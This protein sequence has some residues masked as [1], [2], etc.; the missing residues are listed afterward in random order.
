MQF[1]TPTDNPDVLSQFPRRRHAQALP[2]GELILSI[3]DHR[4]QVTCACR[5]P[6]RPVLLPVGRWFQIE[7]LLPQRGPTATGRFH[8]VGST[9]SSTTDIVGPPHGAHPDGVLDPVQASPAI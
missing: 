4:G 3:Y 6:T 9:A 7:V 5:P 1:R 2:G 8:A